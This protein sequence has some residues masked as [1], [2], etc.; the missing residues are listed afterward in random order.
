[1]QLGAPVRGHSSKQVVL[2]TVEVMEP[3]GPVSGHSSK[4]VVLTTDGVNSGR[5]LDAQ[6][7]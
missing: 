4:Q 2:T 6:A 3:E 1:M 5:V 7:K